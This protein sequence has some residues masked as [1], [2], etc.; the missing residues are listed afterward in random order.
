MK[1]F[2]S[3]YCFILLG[4]ILGVQHGQITLRDQKSAEPVKIFPYRLEFL[5]EADQQLLKQGIPLK[6]LTE[7]NSILEDLFS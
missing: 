5:P 7:L 6:D 3:I 1:G 4:Y 2:R